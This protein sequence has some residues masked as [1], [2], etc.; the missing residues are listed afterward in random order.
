MSEG[1]KDFFSNHGKDLMMGLVFLVGLYFT[2]QA[3]TKDIEILKDKNKELENN[4][5][6]KSAMVLKEQFLQ[7]ELVRIED[8]IADLNSRLD[9]KIKIIKAQDVV[10]SDLTVR[11][12]VLETK[13]EQ[14]ED[15]LS[16]VWKFINKFL[17][18][19]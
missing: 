7:A 18:E 4:K 3:N 13:T 14:N 1:V 8:D 16:G 11:V 15:E 12:S 5:V 2:I 6:S 10:I 17:E 9:K 19:L